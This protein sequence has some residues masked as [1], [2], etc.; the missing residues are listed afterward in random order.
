MGFPL[1]G[2]LLKDLFWQN[3]LLLKAL[4]IE[5]ANFAHFL[6]FPLDGDLLK[7]ILTQLVAFESSKVAW[8]TRKGNSFCKLP[9][10][11]KKYSNTSFDKW[12]LL[13]AQKL[14][15]ENFAYFVSRSLGEI[16]TSIKSWKSKLCW[17]CKLQAWWKTTQRLL[18]VA[19]ESS[20]TWKDWKN[21]KSIFSVQFEFGIIFWGAWAP[22]RLVWI[23]FEST[24]DVPGTSLGRPRDVPG[25]I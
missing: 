6:I 17:F 1:G 23:Y 4:K 15:R 20:Q 21:K 13:K 5:K 9:A 8:K 10:S 7:D 22:C 14:E 19:F 11:W 3:W 2:N 16:E 25:L 12:E 18:L 24:R